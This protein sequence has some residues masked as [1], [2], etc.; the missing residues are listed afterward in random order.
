M[1]RTRVRPGF[2]LI[3]LL[4][5]IAIIA[6]L[7]G[8]LLPALG[9]ARESG[10]QV[11]CA[12]SQKQIYLAIF[13]YGS[14]YKDYHHAKRLN[15]GARFLRINNGGPY[16]STNLR[17]VRPYGPQAAGDGVDNDYAYWGQVYNP[18]FGVEPDEAWYTARM[19]WL[20]DTAPPFPGWKAW[21]CP[22]AKL[23]DPY[24]T[25]TNW[26][27]DH[28][29][30]TYGFNGVRASEPGSTRPLMLWW[31]TV[32][33]RVVGRNI[34]VPTR[35]S[36]VQNPSSLIM[37]QDAFEHMLDANGDTLNDLSQYNPD[38]D[39]GDP[40]FAKWQKEYFRHNSGCNTAWGD[41]HVRAIGKVELNDSLPWYTGIS[42]RR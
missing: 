15:Y 22:S 21:K 41:G 13:Q 1:E 14:D 39:Q 2:T 5:V 18:Y 32:F 30:Q 42:P 33:S 6:L 25:G 17:M 34:D 20:S 40:R 23:M 16:E 9:A 4:V 10:R 37:F 26:E 36:D 11:V 19:P 31:R 35:L 12:N 28:F 29:Y 27:P 38:V 7:I 24:P 3:E 8:I